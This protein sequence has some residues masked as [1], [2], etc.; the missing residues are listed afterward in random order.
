MWGSRNCMI[1]SWYLVEFTG[2]DALEL[3]LLY[4][5]LGIHFDVLMN[6]GR[7]HTISSVGVGELDLRNIWAEVV[8]CIL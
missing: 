6:T 8:F 3:P 2:G 4:S 7:T 5:V 1:F